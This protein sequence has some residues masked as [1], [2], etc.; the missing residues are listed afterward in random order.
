MKSKGFAFSFTCNPRAHRLS[1]VD[2]VEIELKS[3]LH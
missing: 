2:M 1:F 3:N